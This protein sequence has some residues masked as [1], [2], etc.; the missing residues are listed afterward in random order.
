[1]KIVL[2]MIVCSAL[3]QDC[4][5]PQ[6]IPGTY[7]TFYDCMIAGYEEGKKIIKEI[8]KEEMNKH[9]TIVK[10]VCYAPKGEPPLF[11]QYYFH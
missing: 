10:F 4:L 9:R 2:A 11:Q 3:Y 8:G 6:Q 5:P 7:N 1:M